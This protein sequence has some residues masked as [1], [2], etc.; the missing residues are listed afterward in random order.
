MK[1]ITLFALA[2]LII[3]FT[4]ISCKKEKT[5][6]TNYVNS[7]HE[8]IYLS[9]KPNADSVLLSVDPIAGFEQLAEK[10]KDMDEVKNVEN[11]EDGLFVE[12]SN[13]AVVGW[14]IAPE[15]TEERGCIYKDLTKGFSSSKKIDKVCLINQLYN[16]E[17]TLA[18]QSRTAMNILE[19][20]FSNPVVINAEKS[21]ISFYKNEL[22]KYDV[23]YLFTHGT[24]KLKKHYLATG[25]KV[26]SNSS[27][28]LQKDKI[29]IMT[30]IEKRNGEWVY[31]DYYM[32]SEEFIKDSYSTGSFKGTFIYAASCQGLKTDMGLAEAFVSRGASVF[33]GWDDTNSIGHVTASVLFPEL[34]EGK[35]LSSAISNLSPN[36]V[37]DIIYKANLKYYPSTAGNFTLV[38]TSSA[39]VT[40]TISE[41][42]D[43]THNSV[44]FDA[45]VTST[46]NA[47]VTEKGICYSKTNP[48]VNTNDRV[49]KGPG[50]GT[51]TA[52]LT[53]NVK[54]E[55]QYYARPFAIVNGE[56]YYGAVK[57]FYT[58]KEGGSEEVGIVVNGLTWATRNVDKPGTF[59]KNPEDVGMLYQWNRNIGWTAVDPMENNSGGKIWDKTLPPG[60]TWESNNDPC[61]PGW[62]VPTKADFE[63]FTKEG[64]FYS[65]L[66]QVNG[67]YFGNKEQKVFLP[68]CKRRDSNGTL[69]GG[70]LEGRYWSSTNASSQNSY[71]FYQD[72]SGT[73]SSWVNINSGADKRYGYPIRCVKE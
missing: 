64:H 10:Y 24:Y 63:S 71:F 1:K 9:I 72:N 39:P 43:L 53:A 46:N 66:N 2:A 16:S 41:P 44:T 54:P 45:S 18:A 34:L 27:Q 22:S 48:P 70:V 67:R 35:N 5:E 65:S 14:Y 8:K 3:S 4:G 17:H 29:G 33:V 25:Q 62:R 51:F 52:T 50:T 11:G 13:G 68:F 40:F 38:G 32:V 55:T 28:I 69:G 58:K 36:L 61:P 37:T 31:I 49:L 47:T 19:K 73:N 30:C 23:I 7:D 21:D 56:V 12:F 59:T 60:S 20:C 6:K 42:K 15:V 57:P 26:G